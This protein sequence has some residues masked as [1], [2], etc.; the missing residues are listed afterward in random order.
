MAFWTF[1]VDVPMLVPLLCRTALQCIALLI[2]GSHSLVLACA[3]DNDLLLF[4][5]EVLA[6]E[7]SLQSRFDQ[8]SATKCQP[9]PL[10]WQTGHELMLLHMHACV[11]TI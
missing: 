8:A 3:D 11:H 4:R 6:G 2:F 7:V 1:E 10:S 5:C 9:E